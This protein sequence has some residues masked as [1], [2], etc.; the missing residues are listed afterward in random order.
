MLGIVEEAV[1]VVGY[2]KDMIIKKFGNN[3][4][5]IKLTYVVQ[6]KQLGTGHALMIAED[7][8]KE[9]FLVIN[10]DDLYS[11]KDMLSLAKYDNCILAKK[12]NDPSAFGVLVVKRG[13]VIDI[14]EKPKKFI[15]DLINAGMYVFTPEVFQ[16]LKKLKK[17]ER[18]EYEITDAV[19]ELAK[20][21]KMYYEEI[22]GFWIPVG[23]PWQILDANENLL[24][25]ENEISIKGKLEEGVVVEGSIDIGEDSLVGKGTLLKGNIII[26]KNCQIGKNCILSGF[27]AIGDGSVIKNESQLDNVIVGNQSQIE[28]NCW[29]NDSVLGEKTCLSQGVKIEN[30]KEKGTIKVNGNGKFYDSGKEKLGAFVKDNCKITNN[31]QCGEC[32]SNS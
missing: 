7:K 24:E 19:K 5:G 17:S 31:L 20:K 12:V 32:V 6:E 9:K 30:K 4:L 23:Y 28:E 22:K 1:I 10:G 16:I 8:I 18:G 15:S 11:R 27:T 3:Y 29:I 2:K 26:G 14:V 13:K 25:D 21:G